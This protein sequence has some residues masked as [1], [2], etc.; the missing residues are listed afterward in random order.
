M[1][2]VSIHKIMNERY[3]ELSSVLKD[4]SGL[5]TEAR[6]AITELNFAYYCDDFELFSEKVEQVKRLY[7]R[8]QGSLFV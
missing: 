2:T 5:D 6:A 7:V 1:K 4:S 8:P 3:V